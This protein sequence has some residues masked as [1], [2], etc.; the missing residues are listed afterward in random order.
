MYALEVTPERIG[1]VCKPPGSECLSR[2]QIAEFVMNRG[3]RDR[4]ERK[5]QKA[6]CDDACYDAYRCSPGPLR[7]PFEYVFNSTEP[8]CSPMRS[9]QSD[10]NGTKR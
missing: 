6:R 9:R 2:E 4:N 7:E 3:T 5:K 1:Y 10:T 8:L